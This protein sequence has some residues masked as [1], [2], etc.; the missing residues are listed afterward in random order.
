VLHTA[1][2]M[3][4]KAVA[5]ISGVG[6]QV[7]EYSYNLQKQEVIVWER[8]EGGVGISEVFENALRERPLEVYRELLASILC[9]IDLAERENWSS[10][11]ELQTELTNKWKLLANDE[12]ITNI[13]RE[14]YSERQIQGHHQNEESRLVCHPPQGHDGCPA[15][16]QTTSCTG[17][18]EQS[19]RVSR[20][21]GE[22]IL[23]HFIQSVS[24]D[25]LQL[26]TDESTHR[27]IVSPT[28][29]HEDTAGEKF[30]ILLL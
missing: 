11:E 12:V 24:R 17:R 4:Q 10:S 3:L 6:E 25:E 22:A 15:C 5:S 16:I 14:A 20:L 28:I 13:V 27:D 7:L 30:D 29:L 19:M 8:Y 26:L 23:T 21:V 1:A 9:L 18:N 2:H